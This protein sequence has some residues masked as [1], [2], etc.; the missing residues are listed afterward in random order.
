VSNVAKVLS[1]L[2]VSIYDLCVFRN[3]N[4]LKHTFAVDYLISFCFFARL[5]YIAHKLFH[6]VQPSVPIRR[7]AAKGN[8]G[9]NGL[10]VVLAGKR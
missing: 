8:G 5:L 3:G 6:P 2:K 7:P 9:E 10:L 4:V 1:G